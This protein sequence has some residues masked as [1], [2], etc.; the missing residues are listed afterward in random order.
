[1]TDI[2]RLRIWFVVLRTLMLIA[3]AVVLPK[4]NELDQAIRKN[5][6]DD[7]CER[8]TNLIQILQ[9]EL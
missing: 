3:T 6:L 2:L 8:I 7:L 1:M 5:Q 4:P 9:G